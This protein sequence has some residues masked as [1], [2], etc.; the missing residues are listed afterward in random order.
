MDKYNKKILQNKNMFTVFYNDW[1]PYSVNAIN[2]LHDKKINF[3]GYKIRDD[4]SIVLQKLNKFKNITK[5]EE[6]H[7]TRPIIFYNSNDS[8]EFIGGFDKL[9]KFFN[10]RLQV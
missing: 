7:T 1:C 6:S 8:I 2:L 10:K 5:F 3:K 4:F 9:N